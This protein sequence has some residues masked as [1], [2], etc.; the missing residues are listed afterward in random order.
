MFEVCNPR[1]KSIQLYELESLARAG[2]NWIFVGQLLL[3]NT[4]TTAQTFRL[5]LEPPVGKREWKVRLGYLPEITGAKLFY[6]RLKLAW[7]RRSFTEGF[8]LNQAW[9]GVRYAYSDELHQ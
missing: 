9:D 4:N 8:R 1:R 6:L 2:T 7:E 5:E 3:G